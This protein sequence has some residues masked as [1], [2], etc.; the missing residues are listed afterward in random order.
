[1]IEVSLFR[2]FK[3][4][5]FPS[6]NPLSITDEEKKEA[7]THSVR[8][9]PLCKC[10]YQSQ[11]VNPPNGLDY[12]PFWHCPIPLSVKLCEIISYCNVPKFTNFQTL[13]EFDSKHKP[14]N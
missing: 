5:V 12:T 3:C 1:M 14:N 4:W 13:F 7:T 10:G 2:S 8:N 6:P 11:L 9:T